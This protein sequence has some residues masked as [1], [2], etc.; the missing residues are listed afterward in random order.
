MLSNL[1]FILYKEQILHNNK[2]INYEC[3]RVT[4]N[5]DYCNSPN[6][7]TAGMPSNYR[8]LVD[9]LL[10]TKRLRTLWILEY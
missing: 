8:G 9:K 7:I 1:F 2:R 10:F 6:M 5:G 3:E 4:L